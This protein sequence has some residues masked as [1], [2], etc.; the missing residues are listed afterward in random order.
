M[1]TN[2]VIGIISQI[3]D[4]ENLYFTIN[5]NSRCSI[6]DIVSVRNNGEYIL[7]Q[8]KHIQVEYYLENAKQYFI[9]KAA[10]NAVQKIKDNLPRYGQY[11]QAS[12]LGHYTFKDG[13]FLVDKSKVNK[14]TPK[15]LQEV[16]S[17]ELKSVLEIFGLAH[18]GIAVDF[19]HMFDLGY[20]SYP[21][22]ESDVP[23][24]LAFNIELFDRHTYITG[25]TGSGK[26]RLSALIV[27]QLASLGAHVSVLDPHDE[28]TSLIANGLDYSIFKFSSGFSHIDY[29]KNNKVSQQRINF[30]EKL[31]N[32]RTLTKLIPS[33]SKQQ[34]ITVYEL[35][36]KKN[37]EE[38]SVASFITYLISE[39]N[40]EIRKELPK[41]QDQVALIQRNS[42]KISKNDLEFINYFIH[43]VRQI[44]DLDKGSKAGVLIALISKINELREN[45]FIS[46]HE[47][48]WLTNSPNSIDIF[49]I[50]YST[51]EYVRRY[52]NSIIQ[53][54]LRKPNL[55]EKRVFVIDEAHLLLKENEITV[56]L[57]KQLLREGRKYGISVIFVT[58]NSDDIPEEIKSQFQNHFAF[59]EP[60]MTT[61]YFP[62]QICKVSLY[63]AKS[64]FVM[65]VKTISN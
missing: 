38:F 4:D 19:N 21:D 51:N 44:P 45:N 3:I 40:K 53:F 41:I 10:E 34:E 32:A 39:L 18:N 29:D 61:Q 59:R 17:V 14:Y 24:R 43:G 63:G 25:V 23:F 16:C 13:S 46:P 55:D 37:I 47:P 57:I 60:G 56:S 11:A 28:Y 12:I 35:F 22:P 50:D 52:I 15:I 49:D 64:T 5:N 54:F 42:E 33:L 7:A 31:I 62:D 30:F 65:K 9:S 26:S 8:V 27:R 6:S 1:L 58:Q 48:N 36:G 20:L 2:N